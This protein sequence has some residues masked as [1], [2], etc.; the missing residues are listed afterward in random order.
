MDKKIKKYQ[1]AVFNILTEYS[2]TPALP[3]GDIYAGLNYPLGIA[4]LCLIIGAVFLPNGAT[5]TEHDE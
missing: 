1:K 3:G 4:L 2:K 5:N